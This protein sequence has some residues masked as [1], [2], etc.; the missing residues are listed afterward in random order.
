MAT[1]TSTVIMRY[2]MNTVMDITMQS[3]RLVKK[4]DLKPPN[5]VNLIFSV[6]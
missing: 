3:M 5:V 4:G 6:I 1:N 2:G